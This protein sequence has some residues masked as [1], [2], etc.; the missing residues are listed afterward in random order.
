MTPLP[1]ITPTLTPSR[2]F[3][4]SVGERDRWVLA[5]RGPKNRLDP[6]TPYAALW[7]EEIGES[8]EPVPTATIF[9]T[10]REC[11]YRC[12]MC[13]LWR[14]TL[15]ERVPSGAIAAQI[16]HA[17]AQLPPARQVKLYNAGSFFDPQA[18]PPEDYA[19][20][21]AA[22]AGFERV[23]VECHPRLIGERTRT[24]Q[25]LLSG[26]LEVAI[27]LETVH[28]GVLERLNKRFTVT[29]FQRAAA[30]LTENDIALRVFLLLRPPFLSESEGVFWAKCS[31]E[32]A[33][34]AGATVCC[35]IPTR[36]G[37]GAMEALAE[38]GQYTP[39]SLRS[40]ETAQE[41]GL[42]LNH[43]RVF[44]DLWDI[45]TFY[46]CACSPARA[47]RLETMNRTQQIPPP[48]VC[49]H[50]DAEGETVA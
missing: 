45:E 17:L 47:T 40:L 23:I 16:R 10:N 34:V 11:P 24:F 13:D 50:C 21:A 8:G 4:T 22:V 30:F 46:T 29:D 1:Q 37:N 31:L 44:A 12:L 48:V 6:W 27:G 7:E 41:Y 43:G 38:S 15:D 42:T 14:N 36:G 2:I 19:E 18:I 20:I 33:F 9:L 49:S 35:L 26:R 3:P 28:E 5:R 32:V 39:P 25:A